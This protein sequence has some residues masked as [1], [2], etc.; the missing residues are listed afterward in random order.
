MD[1]LATAQS[2]ATS[3]SD[4]WGLSYGYD[5]YANLLSASSTKCSTATLSLSVSTSTNRITN[6]GFTYDAA[7]DLT[8]NG[9]ASYTWNAEGL[10]ASTAG[11]DYTYDG[12]GKRV[13]KSD[14]KL[15]WY[16][17]NGEV[18]AESDLSGTITSEFIYFGGTRIARR[19]TSSGN[20]T[21][22]FIGDRLGSARVVA[23]ATGTVVE[24]SDFQPFGVERVIT[25]NLDNNYKFT[26]HERD[27]E[28]SLDHTLYRQYSS[29]LGRWQSP[30]RMAGK[31]DNA[32]SWNRYS[33]VMNDPTNSID[34]AGLL[35]LVLPGTTAYCDQDPDYFSNSQFMD[36]ISQTFGEPAQCWPW[37][38]SFW[39]TVPPY[40]GILDAA[41]KL[42]DFI[43]SYPFALGERLNIVAHSHGGNVVKLASWS[44]NHLVDTFVTLGT[45]V[46]WDL[47]LMSGGMRMAEGGNY[48][49]VSSND[50]RIQIIGA[51]PLQ[52][53]GYYVNSFLSQQ[54]MFVAQSY[55]WS[56]IVYGKYSYYGKYFKYLALSAF[57]GEIAD[58]WEWTI[59][60]DGNA[61]NNVFLDDL[62]HSDLHTAPVWN[63]IRGRCGL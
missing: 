27:T 36:A 45:P 21:Y 15:Y 44:L 16:G 52:S 58:F 43:N 39:G 8:S 20:P 63:S 19:D 1:R 34:P 35:T 33:Y 32:Q 5:R 59:R 17:I 54:Y 60:Y 10:M 56:V 61:N 46:N 25:D 9:F 22:Y 11:V 37:D 26:G 14:G 29:S 18:L 62:G 28:S 12:D 41:T 24:E 42:A 3:G 53:Y 4:C 55:L 30:D 49:A 50:D 48:C 6:S 2:Q 51:S 7:G 31:P 57:Y 38:S 13:K 23:N 40:G 47:E